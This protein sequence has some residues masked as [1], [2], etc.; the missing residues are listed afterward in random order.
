MSICLMA[1]ALMLALPLAEFSLEWE[2]S[3]EKIRWHEDWQVAG[4]TL[5]L[6]RAA[7]KG[8]GA[9]MEPGD[10]ARLVGGW[11]VWTPDLAPLN[12]LVL[13]SSGVTRGGW[14]LCSGTICREIGAEAGPA[15]VLRPCG[16]R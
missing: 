5:R 10:G 14:T 11:W 16:E 12:R 9:G 15:L 3:V 8:S 4:Q 1:G 6:T 2:H 7:V 13:A